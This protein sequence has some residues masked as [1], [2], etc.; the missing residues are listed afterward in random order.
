MIRRPPKST[1]TDTLL[2]NTTLFRSGRSAAT[3]E[4]RAQAEDVETRLKERIHDGDRTGLEDDVNEALEKHPPLDVINVH[5]LDGLKVVGE[6]FGAGK[7]PLPFVLQLRSA[8]R[9]A[10][11]EGVATFSSRWSPYH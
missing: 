5:L 4:K 3:S 2:P 9:R 8:Q 7:M 10:A 6:L 1:R 11:T